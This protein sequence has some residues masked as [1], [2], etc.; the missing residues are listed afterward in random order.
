MKCNSKEYKDFVYG[1][2]PDDSKKRTC[3]DCKKPIIKKRDAFNFAGMAPFT[4]YCRQCYFKLL[5]E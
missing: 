3:V 4:Y 5:D 1:S 2:L